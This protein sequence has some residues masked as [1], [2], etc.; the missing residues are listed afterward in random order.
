MTSD[1][2]AVRAKEHL[3]GLLSKLPQGERLP[4]ER[5]LADDFGVCRV[6]LRRAIEDLISDGKLERRARSGTYVRR[7]IISSEMRLKSFTEEIRARGQNPSTRVISLKRV[8]ANKS[9]AKTLKIRPG[10]EIFAVVRLRF[11]DG[12]PIALETLKIACRS[13]P[14]LKPEDVETSL[15]DAFVENFG[16]RIMNAKAAIAGFNP[17]EK[18]RSLLEI[19]SKVPCLMIKMLDHDQNGVPVMTAECIYRSDL[20]ELQIDVS[21]TLSTLTNRRV[22]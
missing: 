3:V 15:Y 4:G 18:E 6:T 1:R 14:I 5:I 2:A 12:V 19:P 11:A 16:I 10:E 21:A 8:K 7:P 13:I 9:I 22:S 17:S 20:Y